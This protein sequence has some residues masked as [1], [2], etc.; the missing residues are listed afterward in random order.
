MGGSTHT[1]TD[2]FLSYPGYQD[3]W[4][5]AAGG[6]LLRWCSAAVPHQRKTPEEGEGALKL[7]LVE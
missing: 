2:L 3:A 4:Q 1:H 7:G 5:R 6:P